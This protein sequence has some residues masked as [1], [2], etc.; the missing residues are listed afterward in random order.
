MLRCQNRHILTKKHNDA[1]CNLQ[2]F[3]RY[4]TSRRTITYMQCPRSIYVHCNYLTIFSFSRSHL[5]RTTGSRTSCVE[6]ATATNR[7]TESVKPM[8]RKQQHY[9]L[10][11]YTRG[12]SSSS[13]LSSSFVVKK[14]IAYIKQ[15]LDN[16]A[17]KC[18][19]SCP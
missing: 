3:T 14:P 2:L 8:H 10:V 6:G 19:N 7:Q 1:A 18:S 11:K 9:I 12:I 4:R 16:N 15:F 17:Y 13:S 5:L